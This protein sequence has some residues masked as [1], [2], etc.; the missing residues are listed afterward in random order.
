MPL[1]RP[2]FPCWEGWDK[3]VWLKKPIQHCTQL[4]FC[5]PDDQSIS[6]ATAKN[7]DGN[8]DEWLGNEQLSNGWLGDGRLDGNITAMDSL[9]A[10]RWRWSNA[11]DGWCNGNE[12]LGD[13]QLG[14]E[15]HNGLAMDNL[16]AT[17]W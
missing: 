10:T 12:L 17:G 8:G 2:S 6:N 11:T 9:T 16:M 13:R 4:Q 7:G 1:S 14:T 5:P 3:A 15:W